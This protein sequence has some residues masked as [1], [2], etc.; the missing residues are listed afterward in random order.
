MSI[1]KKAKEELLP[2]WQKILLVLDELAGASG[3]KSLKYEDIV[4][5]AFKKFPE[6][7]HLRG[8]KDYPDSGDLV[9]K[10]LYDMR[11]L[12]LLMANQKV[13]SLTP[14]G[15]QAAKKLRA[16]VSRGGKTHFKPSREVGKELERILGSQ[17]FG[18][19]KEDRTDKILDTD[20][21]QYLGV[22]VH[23]SKN[24]FLNRVE[25]IKY[26]IKEAKGYYS[27]G[28]ASELD[29]YHRFMMDKFN[30]IVQQ[31]SKGK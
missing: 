5:G 11:K 27:K 21:L 25:T 24:E 2:R 23:T 20:F 7:F 16:N 26:S 4:V 6:T 9:H 1:K 12:G 13:F 31:I 14:K 19:Y 10:P 17:A 30:D 18:L 15:I 22:S 3:K 29:K 8:Y 28:I